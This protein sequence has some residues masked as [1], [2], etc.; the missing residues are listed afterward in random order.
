MNSRSLSVFSARRCA[1]SVAQRA[2]RFEE[3]RML[4]AAVKDR[5]LR[6]MMSY[7]TVTDS[8]ISQVLRPHHQSVCDDNILR[9]CVWFV[10]QL[11][12]NGTHT[13]DLQNCKV[14][15]SALLQI[16]CLQLRTILLRGCA[17]ITSEGTLLTD[18]CCLWGFICDMQSLVGKLTSVVKLLKTCSGI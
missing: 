7:G 15:D 12:H 6:I 8:N 3:I 10:F 11:V 5:L 2:E 17:E 13:L 1:F 9:S 14:S 18:H 16:H 4:P